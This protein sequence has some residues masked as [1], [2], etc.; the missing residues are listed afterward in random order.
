MALQIG[1]HDIAALLANRQTTAAQFGLD[2]INDVLQA[3][4]QAHNAIVDQAMSEMADMTSDR[5]RLSGSSA[6]GDMVEADEYGAAPTQ[7]SAPGST[8]GF[9]LRLYQYALGWTRKWLETHTPADMAVAQLGAEKAHL[10]G[11]QRAIKRAIYPSANYTFLDRL[12]APQVELG[13]KRFANAD[14]AA[15]P[16]GPNGES[17]DASTH[18]HYLANATLTAAALLSLVNTVLEHGI[19]AGGKIIL[20][21][22]ATDRTA[23]EALS[24]FKAYPDP[25]VSFVAT[26]VNRQ[27]I[28]V[29]RLDNLAIGTFGAAEVWVKPWAIANYAVAYEAGGAQK[30]LV[31]RTRSGSSDL[32][33]AAEI[34]DYPLQAK[35]MEAEFGVGVWNRTA[36]GV[37]YFAGG[38]YTDPTIT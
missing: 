3:D 6:G 8:V 24:G 37:L 21:I 2:T 28:D 16:D 19:S 35:Y 4:L 9:P 17:Y 27:T 26:D 22:S 38:S 25:R 5:L 1:T 23:V 20:A 34:A 29:T 10:R 33:I 7:R 15:I 36:G 13:V 18:T 30:P 31:M 11:I 14:G 32:Q 12:V